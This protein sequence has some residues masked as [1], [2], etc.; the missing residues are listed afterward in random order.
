MFLFLGFSSAQLTAPRRSGCCS[1][2]TPIPNEYRVIRYG[3]F[4]VPVLTLAWWKENMQVNPFCL[5]DFLRKKAI[6]LNKHWMRM[7][8]MM[9]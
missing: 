1:E 4:L 9:I 3:M 5:S 8:I 6:A 7:N 2:D